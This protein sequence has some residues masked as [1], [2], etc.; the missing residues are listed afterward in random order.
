MLLYLAF[1]NVISKKSS[2]V[3][4]LFIAF[5]VM[6]LVVTNAVFDSTEHGVQETFVSSFTGDIVIRPKYKAPLSLFGDETPVT[7]TLTELPTL[8][9]YDDIQSYLSESPLIMDFVPQVSGIA[10]LGVLPDSEAKIYK[11]ENPGITRALEYSTDGGTTWI[12]V[13]TPGEISGLGA[14]V[15]LLRVKATENYAASDSI[16]ITV[17]APE[18]TKCC[19]FGVPAEKYIGIM[20]SIKILE[21]RPWTEGEK[22]IML[23]KKYADK[24]GAKLGDSLDFVIDEGFSSRSRSG[25]LTA[26]YE[27]SVEN[28]TLDKI[29]LTNPATV[30]AIMDMSDL[31]SS[32]SLKFSDD[33]ENMLN[34]SELDDLFSEAEDVDE[35][36]KTEEIEISRSEIDALQNIY[37]DSTS[38][39]FI[40]C[41]V[42]DSKKT[43][44]VIKSLNKAFEKNDWPCEAVNWRSSA[45]STAFYLFVLRFIMNI[46]IIIILGAGFI[47]VNNTLV[48]NVLDRIREIGTMRA[49]GANK[50]YITKECASETM[51]MAVIAGVLGCVLG[52]IASHVLSA[53]HVTFSNS[54]LIQLFGGSVLSTSVN[55]LNLLGAFLISIFVG[56][57]AWIYP[58]INAL[59]VNPVE[60]MQG[61]K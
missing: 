13:T 28:P 22:G 7:G 14:G 16:S 31:A 30:R 59:H 44:Y 23:S 29:V 10:G 42:T 32:D 34:A 26:I 24:I 61:V 54:F 48:I 60:A 57:I 37:S 47:V 1:K 12:G 2:F 40:I 5:A 19:M 18:Y 21:G 49:I 6:M 17:G 36:V 15:V 50:R 46:G 20:K 38:W 39:N 51:I 35:K 25:V 55:A 11:L 53:A 27:Y 4:I 58:L 45:G 52:I 3:I 41:R 33:V 56:L 8:V 9:P 43:K